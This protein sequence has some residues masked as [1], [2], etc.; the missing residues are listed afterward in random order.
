MLGV[1]SVLTQQSNLYW[2]RMKS[3]EG[4]IP[5]VIGESEFIKVVDREIAILYGGS[6]PIV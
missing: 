4:T 6:S 1:G 3:N 2:R 5:S